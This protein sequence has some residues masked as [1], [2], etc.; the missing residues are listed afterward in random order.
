MCRF[1]QSTERATTVQTYT[2]EETGIKVLRI[3]H[4]WN[5]HHLTRKPGL[6][7]GDQR[8]TESSRC[9]PSWHLYK[10]GL[11]VV[12]V[13]NNCFRSVNRDFSKHNTNLPKSMFNI[14]ERKSCT[15]WFGIVLSS[16]RS[17]SI[18]FS[19][20][21]RWWAWSINCSASL[22]QSH[23]AVSDS[24]NRHSWQ[25]MVTHWWTT[26]SVLCNASR[27]KLTLIDCISNA[28]KWT[29]S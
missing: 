25:H 3:A 15:T 7:C 11:E 8:I 24:W 5:E 6:P 10:H 1:C 27:Q 19:K 18:L 29:Q 9:L 4:C 22:V 21:V 14:P 26:A 28:V 20:T 2:S 12:S 23:P 17:I 16:S 13:V